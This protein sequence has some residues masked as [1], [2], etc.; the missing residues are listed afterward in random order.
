MRKGRIIILALFILYIAVNVWILKGL[1]NLREYEDMLSF[2]CGEGTI[3]PD[4]FSRWKQGEGS[5]MTEDAA[6]WRSDGE[7]VISADST[8]REKKVSCYQIK[9]QPAAI[10]GR[11]LVF[12]R[13]FMEDE[14]QVC[15]L[16]RG[17]VREL[18][19]SEDV[20][21]L[22]V[23][24]EE[25]VYSI[26]GVLEG[27]RLLC[28]IPAE[29]GT[30]FDSVAVCKKSRDI[31]S[32]LTVSLLESSFGSAEEQRTD[33]KLFFVTAWL[34]YSVVTA[35]VLVL[36]GRVGFLSMKDRKM[37]IKGGAWLCRCILILCLGAAVLVLILGIGTASPG[38]DYLPTYWSDFEFFSSLFKEKAEQVR[39]LAVH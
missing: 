34:F 26:A 17:T 2:S 35:A 16:D 11:S 24:L 9:G 22:K 39:S 18:F 5:R 10:F 32:D 12:G 29:E 8:G 33:G 30:V 4:E 7:C 38:S 36:A 19:G 37:Q 25:S 23:Q 13:Y 20:S 28:V 27:E 3:T 14:K 6:V 21:G 1:Y 15:L 31:S